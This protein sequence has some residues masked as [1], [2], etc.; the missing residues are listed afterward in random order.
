MSD[1]TAK[2]AALG[3][4]SILGEAFSLVF[5]NLVPM[6]I[7]ATLPAIAGV[8]LG[9]LIYGPVSL[10]PT[11]AMTDPE[12]YVNEIA[13]IP[14]YMTYLL[15][16]FGF[17]LWGFAAAAVTYAAYATRSGEEISVPRALSTGLKHIGPVVLCMLIGGIAVYVG[18][19]FLIVPGLYL[20]ALWFVIMPAIVIE[21]VGFGAFGRSARLT[22]E[23]RWPVVGLL[24]LYGL[25]MFGI[26]LLSAG[27]QFAFAFLGTLGIILALISG[28][29]VS[30]FFYALGGSIAALTYARLREIK[31]GTEMSS[32]AEVFS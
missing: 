26:S 14:Q 4:G 32:L 10:N 6:M 28:S 15:S 19:V 25:I 31:E 16:I 17:V 11:L 9:L 1:V 27:L 12:A 2:P 13:G 21:G 18:L 22:K 3:V 20:G 8:L 30:G 7:I 24:L 29:L 23:Y 5:S